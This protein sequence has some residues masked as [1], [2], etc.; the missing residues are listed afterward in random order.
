MERHGLC[1]RPED[2]LAA[3][4]TALSSALAVPFHGSHDGRLRYRWHAQKLADYLADAEDDPGLQRLRARAGIE[5]GRIDLIPPG[6]YAA[7]VIWPYTATITRTTRDGYQHEE[8]YR[9]KRVADLA[10]VRITDE[11]VYIYTDPDDAD[12]CYRI[13]RRSTQTRVYVEMSLRTVIER[14]YAHSPSQ[15][16][17]VYR[18]M[19]SPLHS[20]ATDAELSLAVQAGQQ[21]AEQLAEAALAKRIERVQAGLG[22]WRYWDGRWR[23]LAINHNLNDVVEVRRRDGSTSQHLLRREVFPES[24]L[25]LRELQKF[26]CDR[27]Y[28]IAH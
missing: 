19:S 24:A 25:Y 3:S 12:V 22:E 11:W 21:A 5:T 18:M 1:T 28:D 9:A 26:G 16:E 14:E 27:L 2:L 6:E 15:I 20:F 17:P 23:V 8:E 10:G 4:E 7:T 13:T